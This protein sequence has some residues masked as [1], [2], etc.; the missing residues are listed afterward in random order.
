MNVY[1]SDKEQIQMVKSWWKE[2]GPTIIITIALFLLLSSGWHYWQRYLIKQKILASTMYSQMI[3]AQIHKKNSETKVFA[4]NLIKKF[5]RSAYASLA[6]MLLAKEAITTNNLDDAQKNLEWV[7][8]NGKQEELRELARIR[9]AR[10]LI[11]KNKPQDAV[12]LL[13]QSKNSTYAAAKQEVIGDALL[14]QQGEKNEQA[15]AASY[16]KALNEKNEG[17]VSPLLKVK[18]EQLN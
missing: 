8:K 3:E 13:Q 1:L 2:Y 17:V 7:I 9:T 16:R 12:A 18:S 10:I 14:A 6:S 5:P 4:D 15:A 11:A